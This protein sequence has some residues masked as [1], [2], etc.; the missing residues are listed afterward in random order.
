MNQIYISSYMFFLILYYWSLFLKVSNLYCWKRSNS[1]LTSRVGEVVCNGYLNFF[2]ARNMTI[3]IRFWSCCSYQTQSM[4]LKVF[5]KIWS[6]WAKRPVVHNYFKV[7]CRI[8][9]NRPRDSTI[10]PDLVAARSQFWK[11]LL[12]F[13]EPVTW[14]NHTFYAHCKSFTELQHFNR[15]KPGVLNLPVE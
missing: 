6:S 4:I 8:K 11:V 7:I 9:R 14:N 3:Y 2:L 12:C 5:H 10:I 15:Y 1:C 13:P